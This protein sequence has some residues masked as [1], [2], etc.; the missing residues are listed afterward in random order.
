MLYTLNFA[1]ASLLTLSPACNSDAPSIAALNSSNVATVFTVFEIAEGDQ[2]GEATLARLK[3]SDRTSRAANGTLV[4]L[5]ADELLK[6]ANVFAANRLFPQAREYFT[7]FLARFPN[8]TDTAA[9][10][11]GTGRAFYQERNFREALPYF[12]RGASDAL[13][14]TEKGRDCFYYIAPTLLRLN[15]ASE[16]ARQYELYARK[17][18]NGERLEAA[19]LNAIDTWREADNATEAVRVVGVTRARFPNSPTAINSL[20][21]R[22]RL[23][24]SLSKW[25][26]AEQTALELSRANFAKTSTNSSEVSYLRA[27]ALERAERREAAI[28]VYSAIPNSLNNY[29]GGVATERLIALGAKDKDARRIADGRRAQAQTQARLAANQYPLAFREE[30]LRA[31][32]GR[33]VDSRLMLAVMR[34]ES[35][36]NPNAK[37]PAAARGLMQL[38]VDTAA[39]YASQVGINAVTENALYVPQTNLTLAAEYLTQLN[40]MFD[41]LPEAVAASY[42]GGED[43][44]ARWLERATH[45]DSGVF[46][47]EVGFSETKDYVFKVLNNYRAYKLLY[48]PDLRPAR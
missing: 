19:H 23:E 26:Q 13:T 30:T 45:R 10:L 20:F 14:T 31:V 42:N 5:P 2:T 16:A 36:F 4:N 9:A 6:R 41:N 12:Q 28:S 22:L 48:T 21:A 38:T 7:T 8:H 3:E 35:G 1:L 11:F 27:Y 33:A 39:K 43:N 44:A 32:R 46:A 24:I 25:A 17:F 40:Q 37:S 18:P 29:Y 34:Q 47:S 15:R